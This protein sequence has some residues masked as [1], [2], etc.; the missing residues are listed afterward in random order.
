MKVNPD[1][2]DG[3]MG[4]KTS[5]L[6]GICSDG[7]QVPAGS[8]IL[9]EDIVALLGSLIH[10]ISGPRPPGLQ[11]LTAYIWAIGPPPSMKTQMS[12]LANR[13]LPKAEQVPGA[14]HAAHKAQHSQGQ[15]V[16]LHEAAILCGATFSHPN[17]CPWT[18]G[19]RCRQEFLTAQNHNQKS[20]FFS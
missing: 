19:C 11:S 5:K 9:D 17:T 14:H 13:S 15:P 1:P 2:H 7:A 8:F 6:W 3:L 16:H 4:T 10:V 12:T 20:T 18:H